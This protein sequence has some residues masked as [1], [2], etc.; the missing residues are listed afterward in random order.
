MDSLT[1]IRICMRRWYVVIPVLALFAAVGFVLRT[2]ATPSYVVSGSVIIL[3]GP[4]LSPSG[5]GVVNPYV[6]GGGGAR[7]L[8]TALIQDLNSAPARKE[9]SD[10]AGGAGYVV[11]LAQD[12][13]IISMTVTETSAE[14]A[15]RQAEVLVTVIDSRARAL[16]LAAGAPSTQ[17]LRFLQ[18]VPPSSPA[19]LYPSQKKLLAAVA[20]LGVLAAVGC[21]ILVEAFATHDRQRRG[22]RRDKG[23]ETKQTGQ[24]GHEETPLEEP[25]RE[26]PQTGDDSLAEA[27]PR[28]NDTSAYGPR[29]E[30]SDALG[31]ATAKGP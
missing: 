29:Q 7:L 8:G 17:L 4:A 16:Q 6:S 3:P 21:A 18:F 23:S 15:R 10:Q 27:A 2:A 24:G 31:G 13:P 14:S 20:G 9:V 22:L 28:M 12:A 5:L 19:A 1:V 30:R 11:A 25:R 26:L